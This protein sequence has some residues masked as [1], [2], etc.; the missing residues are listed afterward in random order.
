MEAQARFSH[1]RQGKQ[2]AQEGA[3]NGSQAEKRPMTPIARSAETDR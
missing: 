2:G 3:L 1:L